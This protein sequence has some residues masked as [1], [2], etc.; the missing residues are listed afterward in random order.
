[1]TDPSNSQ[2]PLGQ[3]IGEIIDRT[4][5]LV[6]EEIELAKA[7][8]AISLKN[9]LRGSVATIVGGVFAFFGIF[10]L[11]I[12]IAFL[13][14]DAIGD[15]IW[16]GFFIVAIA[17]FVIGGMAAVF[18]LK[19][20][21]KGSHIVPSQAISEAKKTQEAIKA[22]ID[23]EPIQEFESVAVEEIS[24]DIVTDPEAAAK[25]AEE[26]QPAKPKPT[27]IQDDK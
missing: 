9:L 21:K 16:L 6:Y 17:A 19:K 25:A 15:Y 11:L 13:I 18:A 22:E 7:E 1:M 10:I 2:P 4:T 24:G 14:S 3:S 26:A 8:V 20:I 27:F 5:K 23:D 12:G